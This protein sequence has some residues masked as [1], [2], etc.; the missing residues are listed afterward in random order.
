VNLIAHSPLAAKEGLE[1]LMLFLVRDAG[2]TILDAESH[3]LVQPASDVARANSPTHFCAIR[4]HIS[5]RL[6]IRF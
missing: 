5:R 2:T 4:F 1:D 3:S 6:L